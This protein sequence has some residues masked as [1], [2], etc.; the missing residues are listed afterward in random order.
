MQNALVLNIVLKVNFLTVCISVTHLR[1]LLKKLASQ[2]LTS[3]SGVIF[4]C[5]VDWFCIAM[6][7]S[8]SFPPNPSWI[9][10]EIQLLGPFEDIPSW[11]QAAY[12]H[13]YST[14]CSHLCY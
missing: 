4:P 3:F 12:L 13:W 10:L 8:F 11:Q 7:Q 1:A 2:E 6:I 5:F 14:D 9:L